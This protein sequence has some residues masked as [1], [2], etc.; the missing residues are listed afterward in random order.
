MDRYVL[1]KL[2]HRIREL[3]SYIHM[4]SLPVTEL[5]YLEKDDRRY[6]ETVFDDSGWTDLRG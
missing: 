6:S 5:C 2:G 1:E 3:E 4:E